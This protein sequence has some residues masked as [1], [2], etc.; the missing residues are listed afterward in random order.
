MFYILLSMFFSFKLGN[1]SAYLSVRINELTHV[2]HLK[3]LLP[4]I[5]NLKTNKI[6]DLFLLNALTLPTFK[7]F[8]L[9]LPFTT[10][11]LPEPC[12]LYRC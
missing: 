5:N 3:Q 1:N 2:K 7:S 8:K 4:C 9:Y 10:V 11:L 6:Y 12:I